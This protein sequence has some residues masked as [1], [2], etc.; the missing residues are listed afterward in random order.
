VEAGATVSGEKPQ[1]TPSLSDPDQDFHTLADAVWGH[2]GAGE[3]RYGKG[4]VLSGQ[5]LAQTLTD[6]KIEPDFSYIKPQA[7]TAIWFV[8]RHL[9]DSDIYFVNNRQNATERIEVSFRVNGKAPELWHADTGMT[10]QASYR[11]QSDRTVV[12]L[13]LD[14][15]D[16]VFVVF[17]K[18]TQQLKCTLPEV[19]RQPVATVAGPWEVHFQ[20]GRGAPDQATFTQLESWSANSD[21]S[22]RYF[23]GTAAYETSLQAPASWFA[24]GERL[25]IDLGAVKNLAEVL[26]NDQSAGLL[27]KPPFR[28]Y[29]TGLL[30]PG[31][32]R[33]TV[34]V[35]NLWPN[36]LIGDK[37]PNAN[38]VAVT[39][40]NPY[41]A[42][43]PLLDS[44]LLGP[45]TILRVRDAP[46]H[47]PAD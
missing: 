45:V 24:K 41:S 32:N 9:G 4:R 21:P 5:S 25:E 11:M 19:V 34:R 18:P 14:P 2:S 38:P 39:T 23:S 12:P 46:G 6:L 29:I 17:R 42:G 26:V 13:Q 36:R 28:G 20:S 40:F 31:A 22:I 35:T 10:E 3:H 33:L 27:W 30:R 15:H 1:A 37:Q 43:S 47:D 7:D 16:A 44:G 8:H